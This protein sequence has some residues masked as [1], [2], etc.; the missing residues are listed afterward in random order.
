MAFSS[1]VEVLQTVFGYSQFRGEQEKIINHVLAGG[2]ALIF[3]PTGSGKS[4][5]YQIPA[6]LRPGLAIVISPLISLMQNQVSALQQLGIHAVTLNSSLPPAEAYRVTQQLRQNQ[7]DILYVS[8]EKVVTPRFL[9]FLETTPIALFA[10]DEAHC[11]SQWGHDF[12]PEYIQLAIL[13]ER[14]PTVPRLALTAT[15]DVPTQHDIIHYLALKSAKVFKTSLNRP[16][17]GY[18]VTLRTSQLRHQLLQFLTQH[19]GEA[20]IIYCLKRKTVQDIAQWLSQQGWLALPYHAE[21]DS[22]TRQH[23]L[24]RF[25]Y[26]EGVIVVATIAFGMGIDKPNVRFVVHLDLPKSLEEY[27]QQTGRAGR[28]GL[29]AEAWMVYGLQELIMLQ[30]IFSAEADHEHNRIRK[31]KLEA[32]LAYCETTNCRRQALLT[33]FGEQL[34]SPC[35]YCDTCLEPI[36]TWDGTQAAQ[37]ALS[38]V[39]RTGQRFGVHYLIEILLGKTNERIKK[40]RHDHVSTFG[41]GQEL[42]VEQWHSVFRQLLAHGFVTIDMNGHGSI[43]LTEKARPLL[44]G[45]HPLYLRKE[46]SLSSKRD[47]KYHRPL[48]PTLAAQ[49]KT[50]WESLRAKRLELAQAENIPPYMVFHDSTLKEMVQ[51]RPLNLEAFSRLSG[52][53][54]HKLNRYGSIFIKVLQNNINQ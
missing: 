27:Y 46:I 32:M 49:D 38:C 44:R 40:Y 15:A 24:Q 25:L 37:K 16:N 31:H 2:D 17:I 35:G 18:R 41:I 5:C 8:P 45:E 20:G 54:V 50:L 36:A 22:E 39:Y 30:K 19:R 7:L 33:Y 23:H 29:P 4:L 21:L 6:L 13:P 12:R 52:V 14:F 53:G 26:E 42:N 1:P 3:M 34:L 11:I 48:P 51:Y 9:E 43:Q 47:K 28:D 10:V